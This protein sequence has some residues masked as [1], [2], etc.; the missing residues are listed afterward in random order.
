MGAERLSCVDSR[1]RTLAGGDGVRCS[2]G[3]GGVFVYV[4]S[5]SAATVNG[6]AADSVRQNDKKRKIGGAQTC[7]QDVVRLARGAA[8]HRRKIARK[9]R[10]GARG[11]SRGI[12]IHA[13]DLS[14]DVSQPSMDD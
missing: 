7:F 8:V 1:W 10:R 5:A 9:C 12:S 13:R 14:D 6:C 2:G 11:I 4:V 3:D